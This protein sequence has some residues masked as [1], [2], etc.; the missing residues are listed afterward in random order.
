MSFR[1]S[2]DCEPEHVAIARH[3]GESGLTPGDELAAALGLT[4]DRFWGLVN[5][6]W[7]EITGKGW[8]LTQTGR[9]EG[10]GAG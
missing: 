8:V 4:P 7:F 9:K 10:L 3:L 1:K 6:P 5:H 2:K